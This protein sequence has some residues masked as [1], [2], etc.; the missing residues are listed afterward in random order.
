MQPVSSAVLPLVI[1][2]FTNPS[3]LNRISV[4]LTHFKKMREDSRGIEKQFLIGVKMPF[5][6]LNVRSHSAV[7]TTSVSTADFS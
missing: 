7:E 4:G 6:A 1:Q 3:G 5:I 2:E